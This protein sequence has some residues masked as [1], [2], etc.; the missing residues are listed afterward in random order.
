M[1]KSVKL[2]LRIDYK[3]MKY[4]NI[5]NLKY[6][7]KFYLYYLILIAICIGGCVATIISKSYF[8]SVLFGLFGI[9][10]I[11]Q[12]L[13]VEKMIDRQITAYFQHHRPI[14]QEIMI[15]EENIT[16]SS[17]RNPEKELAYE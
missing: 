11:Y 16:I 9:Y 5:Y 1:E 13:N 14:E 10:L 7:R 2:K 12:L 4:F 6:K 17:P 15:D 8:L 3:A